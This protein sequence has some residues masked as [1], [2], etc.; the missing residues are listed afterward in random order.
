MC[1]WQAFCVSGHAQTHFVL[2]LRPPITIDV[3]LVDFFYHSRLII[4]LS[5]GIF[6]ED[7]IVAVDLLFL[8]LVSGSTKAHSTY[9]R[10][11][12]SERQTNVCYLRLSAT[13]ENEQKQNLFR[14]LAG[15]RYHT[16]PESVCSNPSK[17]VSVVC[18]CVYLCM[19]TDVAF[20]LLLHTYRCF[21]LA[22]RLQRVWLSKCPFFLS[23]LILRRCFDAAL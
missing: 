3:P 14:A 22:A 2:P 18:V 12:L 16:D 21:R 11:A 8:R 13:S 4:T 10:N 19:S 1:V 23:H 9:R 17:K 5:A 7:M 20:S 15:R 6:L